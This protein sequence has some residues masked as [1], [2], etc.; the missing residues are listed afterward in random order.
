MTRRAFFQAA[1]APLAVAPLLRSRQG[2]AGGTPTKMGIAWTSYM[3][4]WRPK[5]ANLLLERCP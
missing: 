1:A 4:Y 5:D 2:N 3:S